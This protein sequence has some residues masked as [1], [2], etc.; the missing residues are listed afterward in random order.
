MLGKVSPDDLAAHVFE[1]T[2]IDSPAVLQGPAY[3]EDAAAIDL[4]GGTLVVSSDPISL[5]V[6]RVGTLGVPIAC[7]DVAA[8]GA[9][10]AWLTSVVFLPGEEDSDAL[11]TITEQMQ[12]AAESI[13]VSIVGGHSEYN[14]SLDR[15]LLSLTCMGMT[16]R[17]VPSG[18][19]SPGDRV[20][21]A[22]AAGIE[23]TA[24]LASDFSAELLESG[25]EEAVLERAREFYDEIAVIEEAKA[26]REYATAM[27]DPTE[28]GLIDGLL[29]L[30]SASD[31]S[32]RIGADEI[33]IRSETATVC[34]AL[35]IDPLKIF[36]SGALLATVGA[37]DLD[38][39]L[40]ALGAVASEVAVIGTVQESG[41]PSVDL[42]EREYSTPIRDDLYRMWEER[43]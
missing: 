26:V 1:N 40:D 27:H 39:A 4:P 11:E 28:G 29:E 8:S 14:D 35:S 10:P 21:L 33:P 5:A 18:G 25:V 32:L 36:G 38:A 9:D 31:V 24:I 22:N 19:A 20:V 43:A 23:G 2:G 34:E 3:G 6:D 16:D 15:P 13:G 17:F 7:N 41:E 12:D 37:D 42:G 30:G